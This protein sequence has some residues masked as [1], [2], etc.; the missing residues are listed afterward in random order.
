MAQATQRILIIQPPGTGRETIRTLL[1]HHLPDTA[2]SVETGLKLIQQATDQNQ[3]YEC[4]FLGGFETPDLAGI[5]SEI[6]KDPLHGEPE[7]FACI[8]NM[9]ELETTTYPNLSITKRNAKTGWNIDSMLRSMLAAKRL[10]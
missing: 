8:N 7:I 5:I 6:E 10:T 3:R 9:K 4:I 2:D 1:Y